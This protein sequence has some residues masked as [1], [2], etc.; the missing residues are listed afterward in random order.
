MRN[1]IQLLI[2]RIKG[3][4]SFNIQMHIVMMMSS[5]C[6]ISFLSVWLFQIVFLDDFYRSVKINAMKNNASQISKMVPTV[7]FSINLDAADFN[8]KMQ[9]ISIEN[10][11]CA[12]IVN[13]SNGMTV[14]ANS[15]R[16]NCPITN[17][18]NF[19]IQNLWNATIKNDGKLTLFTNDRLDILD[20]VNVNDKNVRNIVQMQISND[21][22]GDDVLI[23]LSTVIR[24]ID[25][26]TQILESQ[27]WNIVL[28][29]LGCSIVFS[30]LLSKTI[31]SPLKKVNEQ[32]KMLAKGNYDPV[33]DEK[34]Y[35]EISELSKTLNY[36]ANELSKVDKLRKDII[37]NV[38]HDLRTPLTM[39]SGYGEVIRDIPNENT[40]ENVQIIIDEANRLTRMVNNILDIS[41]FQ[42]GN[43]TME[44]EEVNI[45]EVIKDIVLRYQ[46]MLAN[47]DYDI[48]FDF[49]DEIII[50]ADKTRLEQVLYNLLSNAIN[51]SNDEKEIIVK[52]TIIDDK[53]RIDVIDKGVGIAEEDLPYIWDKYH[54][55]TKTDDKHNVGIGLG[56]S[57]AK[58][59]LDEHCAEYGVKS[60]IGKGSDFYFSIN[61][62]K[63][64]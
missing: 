14:S 58:A 60:E 51:Y 31:A 16:P 43:V 45:T 39:I 40:A 1:K 54:C 28:I 36:A 17:L 37:A 27:M 29:I 62:S 57:I 25:I 22:N 41:Q 32:A 55:S 4:K 9:S 11:A 26:V 48:S 33:F 12:V 23:I 2:D 6:L 5:F 63:R 18:S 47:K 64:S 35:Q 53:V 21:L 42:S 24:P 56:L 49:D 50:E 10:D 3:G 19:M 20:E 61:L 13:V 52:Q 44:F 46:K 34:G 59:I 8:I 7:D 38:S 30:Y 15:Y